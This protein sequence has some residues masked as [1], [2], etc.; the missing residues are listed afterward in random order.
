[1]QLKGDNYLW[2]FN[3]LIYK[4]DCLGVHL[5]YQK[6]C[7]VEVWNTLHYWPGLLHGLCDWK[8]LCIFKSQI[9]LSF[10]LSP[11]LNHTSICPQTAYNFRIMISFL[12]ALRTF[13]PSFLR[14]FLQTNTLSVCRSFARHS[15]QNSFL[16]KKRKIERQTDRERQRW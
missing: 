6:Q 10:S 7:K 9:I 8:C 1:M 11:S 5:W 3:S 2:P 15:S 14:Y 16:R 13:L 4:K 12:A